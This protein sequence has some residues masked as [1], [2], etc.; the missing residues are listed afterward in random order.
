MLSQAKTHSGVFTL[1][2]HEASL[3]FAVDRESH[4]AFLE[5][6]RDSQGKQRTQCSTRVCVHA[7]MYAHVCLRECV[8]MCACQ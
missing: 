2:Q 6:P 3:T 1:G 4:G 8:S 7:H 5:Q